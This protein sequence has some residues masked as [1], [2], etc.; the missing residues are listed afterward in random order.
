MYTLSADLVFN[1]K[2]K[3]EEAVDMATKTIG[4]IHN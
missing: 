1:K 3:I 2:I 4:A